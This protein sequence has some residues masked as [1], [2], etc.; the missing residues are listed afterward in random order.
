[1]LLAVI[2]PQPITVSLTNRTPSS[3]TRVSLWI[4]GAEADFVL[5]PHERKTVVLWRFNRDD[6]GLIMVAEREGLRVTESCGYFQW[7]PRWFDVSLAAD[8]ID[9]SQARRLP[10]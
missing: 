4:A 5:G 1:M 7:Q 9:C 2:S 8:A 6:S 3:W 10:W